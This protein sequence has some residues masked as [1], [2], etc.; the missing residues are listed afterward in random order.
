MTV[1]YMAYT[2]ISCNKVSVSRRLFGSAAGAPGLL[3]SVSLIAAA[4]AAAEVMDAAATLVVYATRMCNN[5]CSIAT[6]AAIIMI[7]VP[8][9]EFNGA[10]TDSEANKTAKHVIKVHTRADKSD[11]S[12]LVEYDVSLLQ[13]VQNTAKYKRVSPSMCPRIDM[14]TP[15]LVNAVTMTKLKN[16]S[17]RLIAVSL[18]VRSG[19]DE[20]TAGNTVGDLHNPPSYQF[21]SKNC[22]SSS[23]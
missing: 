22:L 4:A 23:T 1:L 7:R 19:F 20:E 13:T 14:A 21:R 12:N 15:T 2:R 10:C 5:R 18:A 11:V 16:K 3:V 9:T 8:S 6:A 17:L